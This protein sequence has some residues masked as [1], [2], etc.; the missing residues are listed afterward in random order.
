MEY[1]ATKTRL[2]IRG[3]QNSSSDETCQAAISNALYRVFFSRDGHSRRGEGGNAAAVKKRVE[4]SADSE[5]PESHLERDRAAQGLELPKH[6]QRPKQS[7][8]G[9]GSG[10]RLANAN[11]NV[12]VNVPER[13]TR[14]KV[15]TTSSVE[16]LNRSSTRL[17]Y[18]RQAVMPMRVRFH[19]FVAVH[20]VSLAS[21]GDRR[22]TKRGPRTTDTDI[23][24]DFSPLVE[25]VVAPQGCVRS[26]PRTKGSRR[27]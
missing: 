2:R 1:R 22:K 18:S 6:H 8:I 11:V 25:L 19:V 24:I 27:R 26:V 15:T 13:V 12:N 3:T 5:K 20:N 4:A 10:G 21:G 7:S 16:I 17:L 23:D 14:R 9:V